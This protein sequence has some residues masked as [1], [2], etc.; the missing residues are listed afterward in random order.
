MSYEIIEEPTL[1]PTPWNREALDHLSSELVKTKAEMAALLSRESDQPAFDPLKVR[2]MIREL[3]KEGEEP[4]SLVLGKIESAS[5]R[6][7]VSRGF[8]EE[9]GSNLKER[10]FMGLTVVEDPS[11]TRL[12][13]IKDREGDDLSPQTPGLAA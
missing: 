8:G 5:F 3:S 11:P 12:D 2:N 4:T 10:F 13:I 9:S 6:H 1:E 7:F